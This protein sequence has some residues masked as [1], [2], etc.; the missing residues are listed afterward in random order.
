MFH[1]LRHGPN[2]ECVKRRK[3]DTC[4]SGIS[5]FSEG[6]SRQVQMWGSRRVDRL[7]RQHR[8]PQ[9]KNRQKTKNYN[10]KEKELQIRRTNK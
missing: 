9:I 10:A 3:E 7:K 5:L 2:T 4:H 8:S 6:L 1:R